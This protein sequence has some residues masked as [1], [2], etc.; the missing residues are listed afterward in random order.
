VFAGYAY[1]AALKQVAEAKRSADEAHRQANAAED[2]EERQLRAYVALGEFKKVEKFGVGEKPHL[3]I[4]L[5][6]V[7][8]T[9][10]YE[11]TW[12]TGIGVFNY[13]MPADLPVI[14]PYPACSDLMGRPDA[15]HWF[16]GKTRDAEK[17]KDQA[18]TPAEITNLTAGTSA[19][20]FH[21]RICY[22]DIFNKIRRTDFCVL[23]RWQN[24][25]FGDAIFCEKGNSGD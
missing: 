20:Y 17:E 23:W 5:D 14:I 9:P 6:N 13:P 3:I 15:K 12:N 25:R 11:A 8:Q 18:L 2:T 1:L 21:G 7:G 24:G 10:V 4:G 19:V 22:R 16:L